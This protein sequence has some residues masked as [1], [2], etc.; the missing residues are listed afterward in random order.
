MVLP[1][2]KITGGEVK[3]WDVN[4][5]LLTSTATEAKMKKSEKQGKQCRWDRTERTSLTASLVKSGTI[6]IFFGAMNG[7]M[8]LRTCSMSSFASAASLLV[9]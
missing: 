5:H 1:W 6:Y 7:P 8:P 9:S 4:M 3:T 2:G